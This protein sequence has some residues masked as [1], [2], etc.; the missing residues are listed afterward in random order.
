MDSAAMSED[1]LLAL[2]NWWRAYHHGP[3]AEAKDIAEQALCRA[4]DP[5]IDAIRARLEEI[6]A[7]P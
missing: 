2:A 4:L 1:M 3:S 5:R 7:T 6:D